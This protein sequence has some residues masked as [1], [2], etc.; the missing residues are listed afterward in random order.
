MSALKRSKLIVIEGQDRCGK[1]T[2]IDDIC[3]KYD[4]I[5]YYK[6]KMGDEKVDYSNNSCER[7]LFREYSSMLNEMIQLAKKYDYIIVD[8]TLLSDCV[9]ADKNGRKHMF[10]SYF[11][12]SFNYYFDIRIIVLLFNSYDE[13]L[14]RLEMINEDVEFSEQQFNDIHILFEKYANKYNS[15]IIYI[16]ANNTRDEILNDFLHIMNWG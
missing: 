8:R 1:N 3:N 14:M 7:Y 10:E 5:C 11:M 9:F 6:R 4:D 16:Y 15:N 2:L 13:Y 12:Q